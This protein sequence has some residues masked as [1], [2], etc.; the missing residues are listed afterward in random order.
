M[1][2]IDDLKMYNLL[3][4]QPITESVLS[5]VNEI[6]KF[7][8]GLNYSVPQIG[9]IVVYEDIEG[10]ISRCAHVEKVEDGKLYLCKCPSEPFVSIDRRNN[11][12]LTSTSGGDWTWIFIEDLD[13]ID[14]GT[15]EKTFVSF[16][17]RSGA[18]TAVKFNLKVKVWKYKE[19]RSYAEILFEAVSK[20][21]VKR[22]LDEVKETNP[23]DIY[24]A[25]KVFT[26]AFKWDRCFTFSPMLNDESHAFIKLFDRYEIYCYCPTWTIFDKHKV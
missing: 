10:V 18:S 19:I 14:M 25:L 9:D 23:K 24:E 26:N 2:T 3:C 20:N 11:S 5:K 6:V 1:Y 13:K 12:L 21:R 7:R 22:L 15:A 16:F 4:Q 17:G 8:N